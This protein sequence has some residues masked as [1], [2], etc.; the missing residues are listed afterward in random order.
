MSNWNV[1]NIEKSIATSLLTKNTK[2]KDYVGT[3]Q[4]AWVANKN[5]EDVYPVY[6]KGVGLETDFWENRLENLPN[7]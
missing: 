5:I 1:K 7:L 3:E 6:F 2:L 4:K